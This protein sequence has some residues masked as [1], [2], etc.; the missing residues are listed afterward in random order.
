M[1]S[2]LDTQQ[3]A[4]LLKE[5]R[6]ERSLREVAQEMCNVSP[7]TLSR[8]EN[9]KMLD[10]ETFL[11]VCDW[12]G[13]TPQQFI[14]EA[15]QSLLGS[16]AVRYRI[17]GGQRLEGSVVVQGAKNAALPIIAAALLATKGQTILHN[18]PLIRDVF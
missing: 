11:Q 4:V 10:V 13:V 15:R 9:G 5:K 8:I 16:Q 2:I 14:K 6:G 7:A 17:E 12:L 1:N 3:L 18:V